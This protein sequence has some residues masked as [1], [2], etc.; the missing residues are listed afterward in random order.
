[1]NTEK[2]NAPG[3]GGFMEKA[4]KTISYALR[5]RPDQFG[6][7]LDKEGWIGI[8]VD[9]VCA[10]RAWE[11]ASPHHDRERELRHVRHQ[12]GAMPTYGAGVGKTAPSHKGG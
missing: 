12:H 8:A 11:G 6:L 7:A 10:P 1:M 5:H 9:S 4:S 2:D 3:K